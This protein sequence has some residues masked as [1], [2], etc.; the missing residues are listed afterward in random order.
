MNLTLTICVEKNA[1]IRLTGIKSIVTLARSRVIL[2]SLSTEKDSLIAMRLKFYTN[3]IRL[4]FY[5][6]EESVM[7]SYHHDERILLIQT[8]LYFA[9]CI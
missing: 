4:L 3:L 9:Q 2:V 8:F 5:W 7:H 6:D 1:V